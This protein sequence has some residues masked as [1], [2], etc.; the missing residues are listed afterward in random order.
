MGVMMTIMPLMLLSVHCGDDVIHDG[1]EITNAA[2]KMIS[3]TECKHFDSRSTMPVISPSRDC[4]GYEFDGASVLHIKRT[5]AGFNC[6]PDSLTASVETH[7]SVIS[8]DEI[9]WVSQPC[10]CLCL[11]DME[12]DIDGMTAGT[13]TLQFNEPYL[14]EG[15]EILSITI[16][17]AAEPSGSICVERSHYPWGVEH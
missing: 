10:R 15:D 12:Y 7:G 14:Q 4:V 2:V 8:V 3:H 17:L 11:Y 16:D 5:N 9:E 1:G 13:V 6:C